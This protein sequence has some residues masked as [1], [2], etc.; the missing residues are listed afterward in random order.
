M[1]IFPIVSD[2]ALLRYIERVIGIDVEAI[3]A[4]LNCP[5]VRAA[6][7]IGCGT[8]K[9]GNGARLKLRGQHIVTV[10]AKDMT[11]SRDQW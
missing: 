7:E 10:L 11:I 8:V 2:H 6:I 3:R 9:L 1:M 4:E 5:A